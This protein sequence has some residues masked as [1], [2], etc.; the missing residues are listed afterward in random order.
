MIRNICYENIIDLI[1]LHRLSQCLIG[2]VIIIGCWHHIDSHI[3]VLALLFSLLIY[4][5]AV[6]LIY[7][8]QQLQGSNKLLNSTIHSIDGVFCG[9]ICL[10][11]ISSNTLAVSISALFLLIYLQTLGLKAL[12]GIVSLF[13]TVLICSNLDFKA[14]S[15]NSFCKLTELCEH[16][17]YLILIVFLIIYSYLKNSY[18]HRLN[19]HLAQQFNKNN[20]LKA[21]IFSLSKYLSPEISKSIIAGHEVK[22]ESCEKQMT[23]FFSD[24]TGFCQLSEQLSNEKLTWLI[25]TYLEEMSDIIFKFG[26]TLDKVIGDSIMVFFGDPHSRGE[27]N[28]AVACVTMALAMNEAMQKLRHQWL[29]SGIKNPPS[30]RIG[31][32]TGFCKVGNFGTETKLDYTVMGTAVNLASHIESIANSNEIVLSE[33][34]YQ[35]VKDRIQCE[36]KQDDSEWLAKSL[37][38]YSVI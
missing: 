15:L 26:G 27:S 8:S 12:Y 22:V 2:T 37:R 4:Q 28:D 17:I 36:R 19:S 34:T 3:F 21:H 13:C 31:I 23:I 25:N 18:D 5:T 38:L 11:C 33:Q 32:N 35:L 14:Y 6:L 29:D 30:H 16:A 10:I 20:I 7:S 9:I 1:S 24:M